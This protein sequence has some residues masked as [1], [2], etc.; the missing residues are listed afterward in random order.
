M[1]RKYYTRD[2]EDLEQAKAH[3]MFLDRKTQCHEDVCSTSDNVQISQIPNETPIELVF[4]LDKLVL[5]S[6]EKI[7][8]KK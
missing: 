1:W 2:A 4:K 3:A 6:C 5:S 8:K 7:Q